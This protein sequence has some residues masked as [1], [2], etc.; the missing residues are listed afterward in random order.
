M[1]GAKN[2]LSAG[3]EPNMEIIHN[4]VNETRTPQTTPE[5]LLTLLDSQL[6]LARAKRTSGD[7]PRRTALLVGGLLI[8]VAGG[9]AALFVLQQM[10]SDL[11]EHP[12]TPNGQ[13]EQ[14]TAQSNN[15]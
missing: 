12:A 13:T 1:R 14:S 4:A 5:Q 11:R 8:I 15:Y 10:L 7:T 6:T 3:E 9:A 2:A